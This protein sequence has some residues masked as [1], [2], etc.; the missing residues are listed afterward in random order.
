MGATNCGEYVKKGVVISEGLDSKPFES[1]PCRYAPFPVYKQLKTGTRNHFLDR[2]NLASCTCC[3]RKVKAD[4]NCD[5]LPHEV[6]W[7]Q[8]MDARGPM[9]GN[10]VF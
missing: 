7:S 1:F 4:S 8:M 6:I 5:N 2:K 3:T 10:K 9:I